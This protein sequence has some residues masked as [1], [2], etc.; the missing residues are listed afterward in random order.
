VFNIIALS[1]GLAAVKPIE[2][3][4]YE[5]DADVAGIMGDLAK[6]MGFVLENNGVSVTLNNPYFA[7]TALE[8]VKSCAH[9]ANI[10]Y[11]ADRGKLAIWPK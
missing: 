5:G 9:A 10:Y 2:P 8:Q 3:S 1:A 7:G 6:K 11:T 4:S